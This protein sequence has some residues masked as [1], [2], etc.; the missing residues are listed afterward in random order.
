MYSD[1]FTRK[2]YVGLLWVFYFL[3][4]APVYVIHP[5][6]TIRNQNCL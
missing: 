1:I 2:H 6:I 4:N 5:I 3:M